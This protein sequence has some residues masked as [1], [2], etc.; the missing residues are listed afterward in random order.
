MDVQII[1]IGDEILIGQIIDTNSAWI[2][3]LLNK[4]GFRISKIVTVGDGEKEI[5]DAIE[6]SM[7][8]SDLVL[9]TGGLG[10]TKDDITKKVI[11]NY[12]GV[13]MKFSDETWE[14]I[15]KFFKHIGRTTTPAHREQCYMPSNVHLLYNKMGTAPGMWFDKNNKVLISMPGVPYEMKYLMEH[16]VLPKIKEFFSTTP[17][18]HR[19]IRTAGMGE[20][21]IA[22][23]VEKIESNLPDFIKLAFLPNLGHVRL[24]LTGMHESETKLNQILD[25]KVKELEAEISD[26]VY[27]IEDISLEEVVGIKLVEKEMTVSTAESCTGGFISHRL[28]SISG[29]SAYF[30]GSV[31]AYSNAVKINQLGVSEKTLEQHGAVSEAT[32]KEMVQGSLKLLNTDFAIATSGIA[33]P[34]GGT[35]NKPVGTIWIAVGNKEEIKTLKLQ[36]GKHRLKNIEYTSNMALNLLYKFLIDK[37]NP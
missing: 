25:K 27:A 17:I 10:P 6:N 22:E 16:H 7:N 18:A 4:H 8:E 35:P 33:G 5:F 32:V 13:E 3:Q 21:R 12:F 36:L 37:K 29:S 20:S 28:T 30:N 1:T 2:G 24:R 26:I 15:Q 23:R 14:K 31:I 19:T 9:M 34:T 11:A